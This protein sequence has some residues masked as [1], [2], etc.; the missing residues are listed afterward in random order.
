MP[1]ALETSGG[2]HTSAT[3]TVVVSNR[4]R[5]SKLKISTA[6]TTA[7]SLQPAYSQVLFQSKIDR[8][9]VRSRESDRRADRQIPEV[10]KLLYETSA[11]FLSLL[12]G[13]RNF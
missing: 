7:K 2:F 13:A 12:K 6:P 5:N 8:Q 10:K 11:Q 9:R 4:N 3:K 1:S